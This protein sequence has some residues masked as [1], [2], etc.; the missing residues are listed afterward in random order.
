MLSF[1]K[2]ELHNL[3]AEHAGIHWNDQDA[4]DSYGRGDKWKKATARKAVIERH[5][6]KKYG[7]KK[8]EALKAHS[9]AML[10]SISK[11]HY[12][13]HRDEQKTP[14][15]SGKLEKARSVLGVEVHPISALQHAYKHQEGPV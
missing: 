6:E 9:E 13:K 4:M 3:A 2:F 12:S 7:P 8:L 11:M 1:K 5:V 14:K 15:V 10:S